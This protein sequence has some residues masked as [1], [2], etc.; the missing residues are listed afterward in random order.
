MTFVVKPRSLKKWAILTALQI[1]VFALFIVSAG[2]VAS[3]VPKVVNAYRYYASVGSQQTDHKLDDAS[4]SAS[5]LEEELNQAAQ[6]GTI[7][8][9]DFQTKLDQ[10]KTAEDNR[11]R[12][13]GK[14]NPPK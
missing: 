5:R 13:L 10:L 12:A 7:S 6:K 1:G 11:A 2:L 3:Q 9:Q 8:A 4:D 14:Y